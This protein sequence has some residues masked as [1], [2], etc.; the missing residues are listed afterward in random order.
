M[1]HEMSIRLREPASAR[2]STDPPPPNLLHLAPIPEG[3]PAAARI[4]LSALRAPAPDNTSA[5]SPDGGH[6][7][8]LAREAFLVQLEREKRR[9]DRSKASL[10]VATFRFSKE[11]DE[12]DANRL[13][14]LL[15]ARKRETD[16]VGRL[17]DELVAVLLPDT[18]SEGSHQFIRKIT[19]AALGVR[20]AAA[21]ETYP[22]H[23][24]E[25]MSGER[26]E[27]R[28]L[29]EIGAESAV[30]PR[31]AALAV[32]RAIDFVGAAAGLIAFSPLM[33]IVALAIAVDS[34]GP[35]VYKQVRLGRGGRPFVFYKFRSMYRD[36]DD[37]IHRN[38]VR[39]LIESGRRSG[40]ARDESKP[41]SKLESDSRITPVGRFIRKTCLD[42][43]PQLV[44][45]LKGDLSLVGPRPPLPYEA[46][47]YDSWHFRRMLDMKPGVTGLWQVGGGNCA[48]FNDM[49]RMDLRYVRRWS[50]ALDLEILLR[51]VLIV[52]GK[53]GGG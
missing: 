36:A 10:S 31:P 7:D 24:L 47:A 2:Q 33:L 38:Y 49:V 28:P 25:H 12:D 45:V 52:L 27:Y 6:S 46:S 41:W 23:L 53:R 11:A 40:A 13:L 44:N 29:V 15:S 18:G 3:I 8:V 35:L 20:F 30:R 4:S 32:K 37:R 1:T 48:S 9:A 43:L 34:P 16:V 14:E 17:N 21:V 19:N 51:T 5:H 42:E 50:L 39:N 26:G 22:D